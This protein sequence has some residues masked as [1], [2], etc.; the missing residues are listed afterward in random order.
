MRPIHSLIRAAALAATLSLLPSLAFAQQPVRIAQ[1]FASLSFLP[2]W[3][4][5]ALNTFQAEGLNVAVVSP[6]GDPAALA[7]LDAGDVDLAAVGT[8][9]ALRA[10]AKGQTISDRLQ[11]DVESD[12][13]SSGR[14]CVPGEN[15]ASSPAIPCK[16]VSLR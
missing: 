10:A 15:P 6:G 9:S 2:V 16:S 4:A 7:A 1:G 8:E 14:A 5:R 12:P 3:A 13:G 11:P